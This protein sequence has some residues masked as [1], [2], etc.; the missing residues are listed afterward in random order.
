MKMDKKYTVEQLEKLHEYYRPRSF[1][2][3]IKD[4]PKQAK[5]ILEEE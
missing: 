5:L 3:W 2:D 1:V 4:N